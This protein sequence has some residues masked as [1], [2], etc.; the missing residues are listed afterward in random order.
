MNNFLQ[1]AEPAPENAEEWT[2]QVPETTGCV[3]IIENDPEPGSMSNALSGRFTFN[4]AN[5]ALEE[6]SVSPLPSGS[7]QEYLPM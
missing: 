3:V 7:T 2:A 1:K 5:P 4:G 6:Q